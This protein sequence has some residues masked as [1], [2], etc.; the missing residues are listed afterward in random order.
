MHVG[1]AL[2]SVCTIY[3]F[4]TKGTSIHCSAID[5][6]SSVVSIIMM[7]IDDYYHC[8]MNGKMDIL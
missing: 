2:D 6:A 1:C 8:G 4:Y 5:H 3:T 7:N